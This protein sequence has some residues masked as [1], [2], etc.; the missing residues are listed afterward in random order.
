MAR[1]IAGPDNEIDG[2][3]DV[4]IDPLEGRIYERV[5]RIA[6][7]RFGTVRAGR[8]VTAMACSALFGRGVESVVAIGMEISTWSA[9]YRTRRRREGVWCMAHL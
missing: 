9:W 6:I 7:R 1:R 2:A 8:A 4:L 3:L 5:R